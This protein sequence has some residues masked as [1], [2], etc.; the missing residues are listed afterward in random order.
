MASRDVL[1]VGVIL[2]M[3]SIGFFVIY[4]VANQV[5]QKMIGISAIN[6]SAAAVSALQGSQKVTAKMDY[7]IF[8]VFIGLV[9]AIIITG[10]FIGG[11]PIFMAIYFLISIIAVVISTVFAN[12]WETVSQAS[13][14]G[15]SVAAFPITNNLMLNLPIYMAVVAFLGLVVMFAKPYLFGN[16]TSGEY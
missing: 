15:T 12:T 3:L 9:L 16:S 6:Q 10:W 2:F 4:N 1:M 5:T 13:I 8:G 7:V 11:N 14:F